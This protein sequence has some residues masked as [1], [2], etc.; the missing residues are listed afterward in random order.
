MRKKTT[1]DASP[2]K[3][4]WFRFLVLIPL[5]VAL[6]FIARAYIQSVCATYE[7]WT[8]VYMN[9][10]SFDQFGLEDITYTNPNVVE[11]TKIEHFPTGAARVTFKA[12][13]EGETAVTL[14]TDE[15]STYWLMRVQS[16]AIIEGGVNFSGWESIHISVCVFLAV[17][18]A[19]FVSAL[20]RLMRAH[21][22]GYEMVACGGGLVFFLFQFALFVYLY[23]QNSLLAFVDMATM[24]G[25]MADWFALASTPL[26]G[27]LALLVSLSNIS[28]MRHE[29]VR[30]VNLLGVA[31][32]VVWYLAIYVWIRLGS[33]GDQLGWN[34]TVL[35]LV[36][37]VVAVAITFGECLL[38]STIVCAWLASRHQPKQN[39]DYLIV[40]GC[41]IRP[42]G[43]PSPL[44]AGR[45]DR[46][47]VFD[48]ERV[49]AGEPAAIFVPSGG[50]G[51]D[52]VM[53]EA[54]SMAN[55]LQE[56]GVGRERI[57][58]EPKSATTRENMA[59]SR[60]VIEAHAQTDVSEV[61]VGFSTTNYHVF[62]GYVCAHQAG[63]A[64]EGMGAKTK[65]YF[66]PNAFLREFVGLLANQWRGI[67]QTFLIIGLVYAA[68]EYILLL[69]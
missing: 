14:G 8:P 51:P 18:C 48:E 47:R 33:I 23:M 2:T 41:G 67:L 54:E 19:L 58:L 9:G 50:Q 1:N 40:L 13:G 6:F 34:L 21:W 56:H 31:V 64:V 49:A 28:L 53:S 10:I 5:A 22:F 45:V 68:A 59:F 27:I 30:P 69:R 55:Y 11:A 44:L 15:L 17:T 4:L 3:G 36:D 63:M 20:V 16:G 65:A 38:L 24:L 66:W 42:D 32:S 25:S 29:G 37:S 62:R 60:E 46:A 39:K 12:V 7:A 61:T 52:E 35:E 26:M 43:T 57:V